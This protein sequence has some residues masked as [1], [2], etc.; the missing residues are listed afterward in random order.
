MASLRTWLSDLRAFDVG[1]AGRAARVAEQ[2]WLPSRPHL[3]P[4]WAHE[5]VRRSALLRRVARRA[6]RG[7]ASAAE[8]SWEPS[9]HMATAVTRCGSLSN[10]MPGA[11]LENR[12]ARKG[13]VSSN[14]TPSAIFLRFRAFGARGRRNG[15]VEVGA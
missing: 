8:P 11:G 9:R 13:T 15:R 1:M 4:R 14:L 2:S 12:R 7:R 6:R 3:V 10:C 5:V